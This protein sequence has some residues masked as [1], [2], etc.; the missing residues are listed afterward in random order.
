[1]SRDKT[2]YLVFVEKVKPRKNEA[3]LGLFRCVCGNEIVLRVRSVQ[4]SHTRS[5]GCKSSAL[6]T[7]HGKSFTPEY[8]AWLELRK[9]CTEETHP[10][11]H[12]YGG[13]GIQVCARW[14]E[15]DGFENFLSDM[16]TRP[17]PQHS[18][19]RKDNDGNYEPD[20]C[21]WATKTEQARNRRSTVNVKWNGEERC[22]ASWAEFFGVTRQALCQKIKRA[23]V[24]AAMQ[25]YLPL[26]RVSDG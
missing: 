14:L 18:I 16:K 23:G 11:W 26:D 2:N 10:Q 1:M 19:D 20:N 9:R 6:K 21:R 13:R 12:D 3:G 15:E 8:R 24:N 4:G 17:T 7:K 5:C 25:Y 22:L